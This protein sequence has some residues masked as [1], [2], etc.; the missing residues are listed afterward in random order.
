M[1]AKHPGG[2]FLQTSLRQFV[3]GELFVMNVLQYA[4]ITIFEFMLQQKI[5]IIKFIKLLKTTD[6]YVSV[7]KVE[8]RISVFP[9]VE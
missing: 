8:K 1:T 7:W 9:Y 2:G 6:S 3:L 4:E 5:K